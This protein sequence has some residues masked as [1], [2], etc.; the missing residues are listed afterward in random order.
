MWESFKM[1]L[2]VWGIWNCSHDQV[3][4]H[5][6]QIQIRHIER[7]LMWLCKT[8]LIQNW[9][10]FLLYQKIK[11][12]FLFRKWT[13]LFINL[14]FK[15]RKWAFLSI[16]LNFISRKWDFLFINLFF[17]NGKMNLIYVKWTFQNRNLP[18]LKVKLSFLEINLKLINRKWCFLFSN[19]YWRYELW[20]IWVTI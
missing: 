3:R 20:E 2:R 18:F 16:K 5:H 13:F 12:C 19:Q 14:A 7:E 15:N 9:D 1:I 6:K 17:R 11:Q 4:Q 8:H 10:V